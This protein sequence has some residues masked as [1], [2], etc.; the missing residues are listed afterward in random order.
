MGAPVAPAKRRWVPAVAVALALLVAVVSW[1]V[2]RPHSVASPIDAMVADLDALPSPGPDWL[3]SRAF[4]FCS[5]N[6]GCPEA[7]R[8]WRAPT[9]TTTA[10]ACA[11]VTTWA[12]TIHPDAP[13]AADEC[14]ASMGTTRRN[15]EATLN[16]DLALDG[17][18][19]YSRD[20][21]VTLNPT[22]TIDV[23]VFNRNSAVPAT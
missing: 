5:T 15:Y 1:L 20:L 3:D 16:W 23:V 9:G 6:G 19:N 22:G 17:V 10:Q 8:S 21:L 7:H 2:L 18:F 11:S 14:I 12:R 4:P 13:V